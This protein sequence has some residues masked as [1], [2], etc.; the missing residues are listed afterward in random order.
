M[1]YGFLTLLSQLD[2]NSQD[3]GV[4]LIGTFKFKDSEGYV[5]ATFSV[6]EDTEQHPCDRFCIK[7]TMGDDK[8][9]ILSR[10]FQEGFSVFKREFALKI[11]LN[12]DYLENAKV[13]HTLSKLPGSNTWPAYWEDRISTYK[14]KALRF[15]RIREY[16][17]C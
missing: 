7:L 14:L 8:I 10:S 4:G 15:E 11:K 5:Y 12:Q 1:T 2:D 6:S 9:S 17:G 16:L 13:S 3:V